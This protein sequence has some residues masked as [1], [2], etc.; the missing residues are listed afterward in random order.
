MTIRTISVG[1]RP[2]G[3]TSDELDGYVS[4][5]SNAPTVSDVENVLHVCVCMCSKQWRHRVNKPYNATS[6]H[7]GL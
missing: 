6:P 2:A 1:G 7:I 4:V 3:L 5:D